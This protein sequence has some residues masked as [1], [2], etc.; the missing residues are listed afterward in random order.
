MPATHHVREALNGVPTG[1]PIPVDIL[2]KYDAPV[3]ASTVRLWALEL[4]PPLCLWEG[5]DDI[6]RIYPAGVHVLF[7]IPTC[8][9]PGLLVG[10]SAGDADVQQRIKDLQV[11]LQRL[12]KVHL[13]VLEAIFSHIKTYVL[14]PLAVLHKQPSG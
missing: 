6:R 4:N 14:V 7:G 11:A 1:L 5:W 8:T 12:P 3:I 9:D 2:E 10:A 13:Y